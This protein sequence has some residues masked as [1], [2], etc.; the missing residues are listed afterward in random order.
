LLILL[1]ATKWIAG[2]SPKLH[3]GSTKILPVCLPASLRIS[4]LEQW[5]VSG[6]QWNK[7]GKVGSLELSLSP[8]FH[9]TSSSKTPTTKSFR[10]EKKQQAVRR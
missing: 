9:P 8:D 2:C 1:L 3:Q 4:S 7:A 10:E 5:E 6:K